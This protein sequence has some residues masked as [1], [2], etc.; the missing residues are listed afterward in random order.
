MYAKAVVFKFQ[1]GEGGKG[2]ATWQASLPPLGCAPQY[3]L[4]PTV[5]KLLQH[6]C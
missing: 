3:S 1:F 4:L 2:V 6:N 5:Q